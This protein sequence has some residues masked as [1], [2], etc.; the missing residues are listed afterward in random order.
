MLTYLATAQF[1]ERFEP[2]FF[3]PEKIYH[4][5]KKVLKEN[6]GLDDFMEWDGAW[7]HLQAI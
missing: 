3:C 1:E 4:R 7:F 5:E 2:L 6:I